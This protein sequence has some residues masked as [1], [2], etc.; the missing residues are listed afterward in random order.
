[1]SFG[2][3]RHRRIKNSPGD[4]AQGKKR[5]SGFTGQS[6]KRSCCTASGTPSPE[7]GRG[8]PLVRDNWRGGGRG[9]RATFKMMKGQNGRC[10]V[11]PSKSLP[12]V[13]VTQGQRLQKDLWE[14][15]VAGCPGRPLLAQFNQNSVICSFSISAV[16]AA[17]VFFLLEPI[18]AGRAPG[19]PAHCRAPK[20]IF[21]PHIT[22]S[23]RNICLGEN[24]LIQ[25]AAL[26]VHRRKE[27]NPVDGINPLQ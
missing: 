23:M 3:S 1:M 8:E 11:P 21:H 27:F 10:E 25:T 4:M 5:S 7:Y 24:I 18:R 20:L 22:P 26:E 15:S 16:R 13:S 14:L 17:R 2:S 9:A 19:S 12:I 6:E